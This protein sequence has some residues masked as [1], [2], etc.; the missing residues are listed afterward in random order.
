MANGRLLAAPDRVV[1]DIE[2]PLASEGIS[3]EL[4]YEKECDHGRYTIDLTAFVCSTELTQVSG[5]VEK[6]RG[7]NGADIV[8]IPETR[9][10]FRRDQDSERLADKI[11][12]ILCSHGATDE[13]HARCEDLE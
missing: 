13:P 6:R 12:T 11:V 8:L 4:E 3:Y 9:S 2:A 5:G 7:R 1:A 10:F